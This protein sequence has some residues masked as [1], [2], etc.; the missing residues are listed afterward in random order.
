MHYSCSYSIKSAFNSHLSSILRKTIL[1]IT[2][3]LLLLKCLV[4]SKLTNSC[5]SLVI[6]TIQALKVILR[7]VKSTTK[8][9]KVSS[10]LV[11]YQQKQKMPIILIKQRRSLEK[12]HGKVE[13]ITSISLS[14][15]LSFC[16]L[17]GSTLFCLININL[18]Y[19]L[20]RKKK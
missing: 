19:S 11:L 15:I 10:P 3:P 13:I 18:V 8:K 6:K 12:D 1:K 17:V 2:L 7:W 14:G 16:R 5:Y 20:S 9:C 4:N